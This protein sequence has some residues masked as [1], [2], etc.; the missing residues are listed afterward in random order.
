MQACEGRVD[1]AKAVKEHMTMEELRMLDEAYDYFRYKILGYD[2]GQSLSRNTV[3]R[4]KGIIKGKYMAN[5]NVEDAANYSYEVL[6][7]SLKYSLPDIRRGF[8]R[9]KF[10]DEN[11]R[12]NYALKIVEENMNTAYKKLQGMKKAEEKSDS[13]SFVIAEDNGA[14]YIVG[15]RK[16]PNRLKDL[17]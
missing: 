15:D 7:Y 4:L 13:I 17:W 1:M 14:E 9:I 2:E 16:V 8:S 10:T 6:I 5:N 12:I 3:L 11:H